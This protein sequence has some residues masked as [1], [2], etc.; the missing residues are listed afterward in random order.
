MAATDYETLVGIRTLWRQYTGL[1]ET[2]D[3]TD[4]D[5]DVRINDYYV[6]QFS[7]QVRTDDF[8]A[9]FNNDT[10]AT[11]SGEYSLPSNINWLHEPVHLNGSRQSHNF[12]R[13][14]RGSIGSNQELILYRDQDRFWELYPEAD[15]DLTTPPT[16]AIGTGDTTKVLNSA[17]SYTIGSYVYSKAS[18]ETTLS[19]DTIP[20]GKYGAFLLTI[21]DDGDI[22]VT[23]G[24]TNST[25]W[26]TVAQA[27]D[28]LTSRPADS[29]I[30][31]FV[32]VINSGG[33]FV[34]GTTALDAATVT[35]TYTDGDPDL[36]N[37]PE[38]CLVIGRKLFV[39][40]KPDD[41][42][43]IKFPMTLKRPDS[44]DSD[45]SAVFNE[46]WGTA[47]AIG[48]AIAYLVRL[49]D[50]ET[51]ATL[52]GP[53]DASVPGTYNY[54]MSS[55]KGERVQQDTARVIRRSY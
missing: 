22:T 31:G 49:K 4:D 24:A 28:D 25:G 15:R 34:P 23:D 50:S 9:D 1:S 45:S 8:Q 26:D 30:M 35:D 2:A 52:M 38:A 6:N 27:I 10:S 5:I 40:P 53:K 11:D 39:R 55:I 36:R 54:L 43:R 47:I 19:G 32:T 29:V 42:Y 17:F 21:D 12:R 18:V 13:S 33:T 48:D 3:I 20:Q 46:E 14:R 51:V 37:I 16:L 44:L 7:K 41:I